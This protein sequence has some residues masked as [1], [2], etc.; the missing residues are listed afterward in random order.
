MTTRGQA[1]MK[2]GRCNVSEEIYVQLCQFGPYVVFGMPGY[3][4]GPLEGGVPDMVC[5]RTPKHETIQVDPM[6]AIFISLSL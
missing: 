6:I 4:K 2:M 5:A 3:A 1:V